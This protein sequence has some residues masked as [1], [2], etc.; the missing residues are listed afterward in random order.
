LTLYIGIIL[1]QQSQKNPRNNDAKKQR[2]VARLKKWFGLFLSE[3]NAPAITNKA[4]EQTARPLKPL[5]K[6]LLSSRLNT[7]LREHFYQSLIGATS[8][9]INENENALLQ[10]LHKHLLLVSNDL[11][12]LPRL[13]A[14]MPRLMSALRD[15]DS[16]LQELVDII[17]EDPSI[18]ASVLRLSNSSYYSSGNREITT[19]EQA[20]ARLGVNGLRQILAAAVMQPI[21]QVNSPLY[22]RFG[23]LLWEHS[24]IC[25]I[26]AEDLAEHQQEDKFKAYLLG[27]LH[28]MGA[29][30]IFTHIEKLHRDKIIPVAPS[31]QI[32]FDL[33]G[34]H[35]LR[36]S[37]DV[38]RHW[39]LPDDLILALEDQSHDGAPPHILGS[40]LARANELAEL[41]LL[42]QLKAMSQEDVAIVIADMHLPDDFV[43]RLGANND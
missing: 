18:A 35:A 11:P 37:A 28:D 17:R 24:L 4:R 42:M 36:L 41:R 25:A 29:K 3:D 2:F 22:A 13:P 32:L 31:P 39:Q 7:R 15:S 9:D 16:S 1:N 26:C 12:N 20:V 10:T 21:V 40:I 19:I 5:D 27:L 38:A 6:T 34:R 8:T 23:K 30:V 33:L 14:I 43:S